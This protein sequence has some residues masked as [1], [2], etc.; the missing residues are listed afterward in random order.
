MSRLCST[1]KQNLGAIL[2]G[3]ITSFLVHHTNTLEEAMHRK[4]IS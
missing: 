4:F 3:K 2:L 1:S